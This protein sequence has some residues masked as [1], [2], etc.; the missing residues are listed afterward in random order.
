MI[1]LLFYLKTV[2]L[3]IKTWTEADVLF[4]LLGEQNFVDTVLDLFNKH[5]PNSLSTLVLKNNLLREYATD[6]LIN[7]FV[8]NRS[9]ENDDLI[10]LAVLYLQRY[11]HAE[12]KTILETVPIDDLRRILEANWELLFDTSFSSKAKGNAATFSELTAILID[13]KPNMLAEL[14]AHLITDTKAVNLEKVMKVIILKNSIYG[15]HH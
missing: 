4:T 13:R 15:I 5:D 9:T 14:L 2:L 11:M 1:G 3:Q 8:Q 10:A 7:I 12:A 6:K